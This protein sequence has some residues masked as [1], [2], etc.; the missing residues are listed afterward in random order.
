MFFLQGFTRDGLVVQKSVEILQYTYQK[1]YINRSSL[2]SEYHA[3]LVFFQATGHG[4][5][6][7]D[8]IKSI[9]LTW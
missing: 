5:V 8:M 1:G 4:G 9:R 2:G 7:N 6:Q 3:E